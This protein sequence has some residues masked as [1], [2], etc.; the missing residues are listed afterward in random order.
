MLTGRSVVV[1]GC[2]GNK[3]VD[4]VEADVLNAIVG[5][6]SQ[7]EIAAGGLDEWRV[8]TATEATDDRRRVA[9]RTVDHLQIVVRAV[10]R[11]L[12]VKLAAEIQSYP[13][14]R[15]RCNNATRRL[16]TEFTGLRDQ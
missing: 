15:R 4:N 13:V 5:V 14:I 7:P 2:G 3:L 16:G 9:E 1:V 10:F 6:E 11:R 12:D 8:T